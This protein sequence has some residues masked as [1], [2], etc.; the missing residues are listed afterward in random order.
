L[1]TLFAVQQ[2]EHE[3]RQPR[4]LFAPLRLLE[5]GASDPP[6]RPG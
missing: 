5:P 2:A 4:L 6:T 1:P 3:R